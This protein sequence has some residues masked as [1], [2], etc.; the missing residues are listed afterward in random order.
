MEFCGNEINTIQLAYKLIG[1][2]TEHPKK[3]LPG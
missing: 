3:S 1:I 2:H